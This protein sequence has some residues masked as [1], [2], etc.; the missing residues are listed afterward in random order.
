MAYSVCNEEALAAKFQKFQKD[1]SHI[2][3][4]E[5]GGTY[6]LPRGSNPTI[7]L[8]LLVWQPISSTSNC[9]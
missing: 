9:F 3:A 6:S 4:G 2:S 5:N 1:N 8:M 7:E